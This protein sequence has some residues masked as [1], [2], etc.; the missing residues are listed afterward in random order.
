MKESVLTAFH[1]VSG[2][3]EASLDLDEI[4]YATLAAVTAGESFGFNRAFVLLHEDGRLKGYFA[5]GPRSRREADE[6]WRKLAE[7]GLTLSDII[8]SFDRNKF[9]NEKLKF[10]DALKAWEKFAQETELTQR[11]REQR[12][13]FVLKSDEAADPSIFDILEVKEIAFVPLHSREGFI[14]V[15]TADNFVTLQAIDDNDLIALEAFAAQASLAI[16][17]ALLFR[18]LQEKVAE[19]ERLNRQLIESQR[20][21]I[22]LEKRAAIGELINHIVHEIKNPIVV[23]GGIAHALMEELPHDSPLQVYIRTILD[24]VTKLDNLLIDTVR[25]L[26]TLASEKP[27]PVDVNELIITKIKEMQGYLSASNVKVQLSLADK[28]PKPHLPKKAFDSVLDYLIGNA[29]E[30]MPNGGTLTIRSMFH[31]EKIS[32]SIEDTGIGI[33][34]EHLDHIF[35]P[36]FTTKAKGSGLGLYN[37]RQ[38]IRSIGGKIYVES[39]VGKGTKFSIEI[40]V[41]MHK[42]ESSEL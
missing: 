24:A 6:L 18:K 15:I 38:I 33:P 41:L 27:E 34:K 11:I 1:A 32:V 28:L 14:G 29:I 42:A 10:S 3:L 13:A 23:I 39:E 9:E 2:V 21:I 19:L 5:M 20:Q 37:V 4:L 25:G 35:E 36:F 31:E 8:K 17:R 26:R 22:E 7:S 16:S 40:P 12:H 30:A